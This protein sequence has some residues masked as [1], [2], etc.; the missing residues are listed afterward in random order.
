MSDFQEQIKRFND[1]YSIASN[2]NPTNLG[3]TRLDDFINILKEEIEEYKE[4]RHNLSLAQ[5]KDLFHTVAMVGLYDL[6]MDIQVYCASE[7]RRWGMDND[8]GLAAVM[9][10]NFSKLGPDGFPIH[11]ARGKVLKGPNFFPP[12]DELTSILFPKEA[13]C[14]RLL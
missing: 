10:S 12:E 9:E 3:V 13:I 4:I 5:D 7:A 2:D 11:D 14:K 6:L 8:K 1:M